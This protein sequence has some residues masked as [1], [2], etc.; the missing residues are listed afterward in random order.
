MELKEGDILSLSGSKPDRRNI[1]FI[2]VR[3]SRGNTL[4]VEYAVVRR[5]GVR[6]RRGGVLDF[7]LAGSRILLRLTRMNRN[8]I[9]NLVL[10]GVT[11][12]AEK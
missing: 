6:P 7:D 12:D 4:L 5:K 1:N 8:R 11:K 9:A 2:V 3:R 10:L